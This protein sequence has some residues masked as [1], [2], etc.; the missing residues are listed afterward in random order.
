MIATLVAT[1]L[2]AAPAH[3]EE[4]TAPSSAESAPLPD[5]NP[6]R[7]KRKHP[8]LGTY[9]FRAAIPAGGGA[10]TTRVALVEDFDGPFIGEVT[11][12]GQ[13]AWRHFGVAVELAGTGGVS[14]L[15]ASAGLGNLVLDARWIFGGRSTHALGLRGTFGVG[16]RG[17]PLEN[18]AWWG[19]VPEAT[20]PSTGVALAYEGAAGRWV[21]HA[22]AGFRSYPYW[23][24]GY[25]TDSLDVGVLVGTVQPVAERWAVVAEGEV[26]LSAS[27]FHLRALARRDLGAGWT[28]DVGLAVPL[29][30]M[31]G[32]PTLQVIGRIDRRL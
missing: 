8:R 13:Y 20:V 26:A 18:V 17:A 2:A 5:P 22:R 27:P 21:W 30:A 10:A 11:V 24:A 14:P 4:P 32:D 9:A 15:W 1:L 31:L 16:A 28:A 12:R 3:A 19:T 6:R 25:L 7:A 23:G 29:P